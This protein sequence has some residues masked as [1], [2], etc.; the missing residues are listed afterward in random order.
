MKRSL[1]ILWILLI[2][3]AS[4]AQEYL[5][6]A[7]YSIPLATKSTVVCELPFFDDFSNYE[8]A[9]SPALW[10]STQAF[11]S[12]GYGNFPPTIGTV[13][14][15]AVDGHG[16]L[17]PGASTNPFSGDT[18]LSAVIRL[19]S[20][21]KPIHKELHP[22]DSVYLSFY[23]LPGGGS[24]DMWVRNGDVPEPNDSLILEFYNPKQDKWEHIWSVGGISV[25]TL[26]S[27]TGHAWQ[28]V[29]IAITKE[30]YFSNQFKFRFRNYCSLDKMS[31]TG[32]IGNSDH[33]HLD[34]IYLDHNR[35]RNN[36]YEVDV[37][38]VNPAPS[39]L[40]EYQAMPARQFDTSDMYKKLSLTITNR[41][42][43]KMATQYNYYV[44]DQAGN[45]I[46]KYDGGNENVPSYFPLGT[47]QTAEA[48][49][50][51]KVN[52][53]FNMTTTQRDYDVFHVV[54]GSVANDNHPQNDTLRF[55]QVFRNYYAY[56]D[57]VA[58][59]GYGLTSTSSTVKLAYM[60]PL[61]VKDTL[62]A[63]DLYF[64]RTRNDENEFI[65]F[66]LCIWAD[67][68]GQP[69]ELIYKDTQRR[70][71]IFSE[72]NQFVRYILEDEVVVE[73]KIYVGFEQTS[74]DYINLGFDRNHDASSNIYYLTSGHWQQS[75]LKGALMM[76]PYFG[77]AATI[78][79]NDIQPPLGKI[80]P[81]PAQHFIHVE[82]AENILVQF[83]NVQGQLLYQQQHPTQISLDE[84]QS[85]IYIVRFIDTDTYTSTTQKL[86]IQ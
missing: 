20:L 82:V 60:F 79:I 63:I 69:G 48:H 42:S 41:Y 21:F 3:L 68:N 72:L 78:G 77:H 80:Y 44:Y 64:N 38:F 30:D 37:A 66:Y 81:N 19:D 57:G 73:G 32:L 31:K 67:D 62:T 17:Y 7:A 35:K 74:N 34:Y 6:P 75:I 40:K 1:L 23:Y 50:N 27:H 47:Y 53:K 71:P 45:Q 16:E 56:D 43:E 22:S 5:S 28:Y 49:A 83:Y 2:P 36:E 51:P 86:I 13:T 9:P 10:N 26:I 33:W 54:R 46:S 84:F 59:N 58:E 15:D 52:F 11:V 55:K 65:Y 18:L 76:R 29:S 8:G 4:L 85:G 24:G 14:L 39:F 12:N 70:L 61:R 25:D